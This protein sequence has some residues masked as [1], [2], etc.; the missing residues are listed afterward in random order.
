MS[1]AARPAP[2]PD[3]MATPNQSCVL[4]TLVSTVHVNPESLDVQMLPP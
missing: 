1:N 2:T 3:D 4:P